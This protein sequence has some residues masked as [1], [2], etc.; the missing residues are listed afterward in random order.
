MDRTWQACFMAYEQARIRHEDQV[1][2]NDGFPIVAWL[3]AAGDGP[4]TQKKSAK[5][6]LDRVER[7]IKSRNYKSF[8]RGVQ[9][10]EN[11][12]YTYRKALGAWLTRI[13]GMR[14]LS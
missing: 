14:S 2:I 6:Y 5:S 1:R 13:T 9:S 3:V 10:Y 4:V 7:T 11:A 8:M 12:V